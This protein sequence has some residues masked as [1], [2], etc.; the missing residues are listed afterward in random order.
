MAQGWAGGASPTALKL[1]CAPCLVTEDR[2]VPSRT[3]INGTLLC[4]AHAKV[5]VAHG[6]VNTIDDLFKLSLA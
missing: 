3:Q 4:L 5:W 6:G 1:E 2:S